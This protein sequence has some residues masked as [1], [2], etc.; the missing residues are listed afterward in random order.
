MKVAH[1]DH[2]E[3]LDGWR[4]GVDYFIG[5]LHYAMTVE[6]LSYSSVVNRQGCWELSE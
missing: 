4:Q 1:V 3:W 6:Q 2:N 5:P